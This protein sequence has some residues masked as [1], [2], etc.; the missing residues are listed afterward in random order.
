MAAY[1]TKSSGI[2]EWWVTFSV[3]SRNMDYRNVDSNANKAKQYEAV[4]VF[5]NESFFGPI[6]TTP[7]QDDINEFEKAEL[8]KN[9]KEE[10][11]MIKKSY[12]RIMEK[13]KLNCDKSLVML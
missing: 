9:V 12:L 6:T 3:P 10:K 1:S 7:I 8:L 2:L 4:R 13:I 11:P 5:F